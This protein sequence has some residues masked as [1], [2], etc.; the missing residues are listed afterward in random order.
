MV[1]HSFPDKTP[2]PPYPIPPRYLLA[3]SAGKILYRYIHSHLQ[4]AKYILHEEVRLRYHHRLQT[5]DDPANT[6]GMIWPVKLSQ[7]YFIHLVEDSP[8]D[9]RII[10]IHE[11]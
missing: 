1:L 10:T 5:L 9:D 3:N 6:S 4:L 2:T 7:Q 11:S 8:Y